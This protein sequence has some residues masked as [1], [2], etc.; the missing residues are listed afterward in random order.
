MDRDQKLVRTTEYRDKAGAIT[1]G[2][3]P[4]YVINLGWLDADKKAAAILCR[5]CAEPVSTIPAVYATPWFY[6]RTRTGRE[7]YQL[8]GFTPEEEQRIRAEVD[9]YLATHI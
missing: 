1:A 7:V 2:S 3:L 6:V 9:E 8:E 4:P 5:A